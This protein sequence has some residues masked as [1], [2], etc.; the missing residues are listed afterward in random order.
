MAPSL[1]VGGFAAI[2]HH[3]LGGGCVVWR[4]LAWCEVV[5]YGAVW[6][7]GPWCGMVWCDMVLS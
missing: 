1:I 5:W 7:G 6:R 3:L 2:W 4:D